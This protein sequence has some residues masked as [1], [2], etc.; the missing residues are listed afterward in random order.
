MDQ[1][2][3][4]MSPSQSTFPS[5][6]QPCAKVGVVGQPWLFSLRNKRNRGA[7]KQNDLPRVLLQ[8]LAGLGFRGGSIRPPSGGT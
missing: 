7:E 5:L 4:F 1:G 6:S 3:A 8:P 2:L